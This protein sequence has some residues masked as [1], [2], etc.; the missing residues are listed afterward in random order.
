MSRI[1]GDIPRCLNQRD[2]ILVGATN[3]KEHNETL[4]RLFQKAEDYEIAFIKPKCVFGEARI[5]FYSCQFGGGGLK[6]TPQK[7][8]GIHKC[9]KAE[10]RSFL[11]MTVYLSKF[12]PLY[13]SLTKP[14]RELTHKDSKFHLRSEESN[15]FNKDAMVFLNLMLS[16]MVRVESN[17]NERLSPRAGNHCFS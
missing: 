6:S 8:Q 12:I 13:A 3:W 9:Q 2:D 7:V 14:L 1:F 11:G 15:A 4:E 17:Y 5:T 16:I 10:V